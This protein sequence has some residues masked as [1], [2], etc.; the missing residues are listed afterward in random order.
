MA[1]RITESL[2]SSI[3]IQLSSLENGQILIN[4]TGHCAG[5]EVAGNIEELIAGGI[6][7]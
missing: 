2:D 4:E 3:H 5:L 7:R 1:G 6:M